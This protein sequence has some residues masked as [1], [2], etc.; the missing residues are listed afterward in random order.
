MSVRLRKQVN[1]TTISFY[2]DIAAH[3][4]RTRKYLNLWLYPK[5]KD[6]EQRNHNAQAKV[7]ADRRLSEEQTN[8]MYELQDIISPAK[9]EQ[10]VTDYFS[11]FQKKYKNKDFRKVDAALYHFK[12]FQRGNKLKFKEVNENTIS[13]FKKY[14]EHKRSGETARAYFGKFK[15][16]MKRAHIDRLCRYDIRTFEARFKIDKNRL[17]KE[18]LLPEEIQLIADTPC[19]NKTIKLAFIFCCY[20]G[21]DFADVFELTWKHIRNGEMIKPRQKT[22]VGRLTPL[23]VTAMS[24]LSMLD[25]ETEFVFQDLPNRKNRTHSWQACNKTLGN[26]VKNAGIK[27]HITF[28]VGRHSFATNLEG[29]EG[30]VA[31]LLGHSDTQMVKVYRRVKRERLQ[32]AVDSLKGVKVS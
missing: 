4:K 8:L 19:G 9:Q 15:Q 32:K 25:T 27:K 28:H 17:K 16:V 13:D 14:L 24:I 6:A 11:E 30:T 21:L 23:H 22:N 29:D 10:L 12:E 31:Q 18:I 5:P 26:L 1:K 20:T 7:L 3:G 2:L